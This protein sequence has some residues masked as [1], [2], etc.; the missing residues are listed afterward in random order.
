MEHL[1]ALEGLAVRLLTFLSFFFFWILDF[2]S[3][4]DLRDMGPSP[5][6]GSVLGAEST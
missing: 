4:C 2:D 1:G 3:G 6:L 5:T